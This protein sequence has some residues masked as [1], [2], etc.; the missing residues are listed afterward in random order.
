MAQPAS[1]LVF[2]SFLS[3]IEPANSEVL[4]HSSMLQAGIYTGTNFVDPGSRIS[5]MTA[6]IAFFFVAASVLDNAVFLYHPAA[7]GLEVE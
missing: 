1:I 2:L 4:G 3:K 5:G 7:E 6:F